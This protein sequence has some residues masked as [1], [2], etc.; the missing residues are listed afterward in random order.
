M[1]RITT[2]AFLA[3]LS[4]FL[5]SPAAGQPAGVPAPD[6]YANTPEED[7]GPAP[8]ATDVGE[9]P[10]PEPKAEPKPPHEEPETVVDAIKDV[11]VLVE[12]ARNGNWVFFTGLL[13]MLIIFVLDKLVK[14]KE[15]ISPKAVPWVA[16]VFG[17]VGSV[18][19]Q[20]TTG[21]PWG[22]A[23]LQG[24]TAGIAAAGLWELIFQ[25]LLKKKSEAPGE[26]EP[27]PSPSD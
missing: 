15:R 13:I 20:L 14:L 4:L 18:A 7:A 19:A 10:K 25:H 26:P 24:F 23:L 9:S 22:Q 27:E 2:F 11:G 12:A 5:A 6:A 3:L 17:I 8:A 1:R 21:I 16:A